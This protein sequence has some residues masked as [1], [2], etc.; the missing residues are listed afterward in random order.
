MEI[1]IRALRSGLFTRDARHA[2]MKW[3]VQRSW[4]GISEYIHPRYMHGSEEH[5]RRATGTQKKSSAS[6]K[7]V[8]SGSHWS[9]F[10]RMLGSFGRGGDLKQSQTSRTALR[11]CSFR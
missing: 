8:A 7:N 9:T 2:T 5:P 6:L 10:T 11:F 4:R 1:E 3:R